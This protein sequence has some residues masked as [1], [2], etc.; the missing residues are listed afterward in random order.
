MRT[1]NILVFLLV[2]STSL[3][4]T[5]AKSYRA[6]SPGGDVTLEVSDSPQGVTYSISHD[7][8]QVIK[9]SVASID[10]AGKKSPRAITRAKLTTR[11]REHINAPFYRQ[12]AF[13]VAW[14]ALNVRL[15]NGTSIEFRVYDDGVAY[16]HVTHDRGRKHV[17]NGETATITF[18]PEAT[19]YLPYSNNSRN[20]LDASFQNRYAVVK[21]SEAP[22]TLAFLPVTASV[23][24]GLKVTILESDLISYPGMWLKPSSSAGTLN[25][26]FAPLPVSTTT[27]KWRCKELV[28]NVADHIAQT[29]GSRTYPW[30]IFAITTSDT[31][32]PVNNLVYALARPSV[33]DDTSWIKP[34]KV[35][36]DWWNDWGL[37][38]VDFAAGINNETYKHYIDF[39]SKNGLEYVILD[40]GW[41]DPKGGDMLSTIP[42]INLPELIAYGKQRGVDIVLWTVFK[43]LDRQL[44]EAC[45]LYSAMGI[46]GFKVDFLDRDDQAAVEMTQRI[47]DAAARHHL[48]LD[49]HGIYKPVGLNRTY[50]NL[51]NIESV[52]GME[53]VKWSNPG[54]DMPLY[55]VTFPFIRMM[56][57]HVDYTPGAMVNANRKEWTPNYSH[58]S[59]MGTRCHQ[60]ASYI[61][62][63]S[64]FTML[65]DSPSNYEPEQETVD[66]IASL[67]T[68]CDTT[69][70]LQGEMG[71]YIVTARRQGAI[72]TVGGLTDWNPRDITLDCSFLPST[73]KYRAVAMLDGV[74]ASRQA[75]DYRLDTLTVDHSSRIPV[76]MAS[77][78]GFAMRFE[79]QPPAHSEVTTVPESMRHRVDPFYKKYVESDGLYVVTSENVSDAALG[80]AADIVGYMLLKRPDIKSYMVDKGCHLMVIGRNE[81]TCDIPEFHHICTDN[82]DTIAF[83]NWRAR[84]FGGA[85]EDDFSA[86]CGEENL[87]ALPTDKYV[88][89][90]I[91]IH[92]FA[93]LIHQIGITGTDPGFNDRLEA[94]YQRA[95]ARGLWKDTYAISNKEEYFAEMVQSFFNCNRWSETPNRVH[96]H[97]NRRHKLKAYDPEGYKLLTE[98]FYEIEIPIRNTIHK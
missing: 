98:Y 84:G 32:M 2:T 89:E 64:P 66:F 44:E 35:A 21:P 90:N 9:P 27:D 51:L 6:S 56:A 22:D 33:V 92:E 85:P 70:I 57:G 48:V 15:D 94:L 68:E 10:I 17:V 79:P 96:N 23:G 77:G 25:G 91:L 47:A 95:K 14:N 40:E 37:K 58:P 65:C 83:W 88:G 52:F 1:K 49:Y 50:P 72:W 41:Y 11:H 8:T 62:H 5:S 42:E 61:V 7:N 45:K 26:F 86:S 60:V 39:A 73:G 53:E 19:L 82:P 36:W 93:H 63:D 24:S 12:R 16:R 30:R 29:D 78:G 55:D 54:T 97:V 87:L 18:P 46:A 3:G 34:G 80:L 81:Q 59:S 28:T 38:G 13:D 69:I 74:N 43:V 4:V 75:S 31:Q 67:P 20:P 71:K 76:A